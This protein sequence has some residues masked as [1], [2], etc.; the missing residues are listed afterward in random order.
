MILVVAL[1]FATALP[2][3]AAAA[4]P[5]ASDADGY[6]YA[7]T[8]PGTHCR[9]SLDAPSWGDCTNNVN[10]VVNNGF[11]QTYD[12]VNLY[13]G[14]GYA[15]AWA[16]IGR[17]DTWFPLSSGQWIFSWGP[18]KR[19]YWESLFNNIASSKWVSRCGN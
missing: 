11:Q 15:G 3:G 12:K 13:W 4:P 6:V 17:G 19:G 14:A 1:S 2:A 9:W 10:A 16:C 7:Y 5:T 8:E 18:G